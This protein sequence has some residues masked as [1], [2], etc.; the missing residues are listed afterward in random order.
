MKDIEEFK[1][2][3]PGLYETIFDEGAKAGYDDGFVKGEASGIEKGKAEGI[4]EGK[5][6]GAKME[7]ERIRN[8][9]AQL[10]PGHEKLIETLKFDG[11]TTG[12]QAAVKILQAEKELRLTVSA[13]LTQDAPP[14]VAAVAAPEVEDSGKVDK[15]LPIEKRAQAE[16]DKNP[17]LRAEFMNNFDAYLAFEKANEAG[18]V[19]ILRKS[20]Q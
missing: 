12:E 17:D 10:I 9:E 18:Q 6:E 4:A 7:R 19:R 2:K 3:Y 14:A 20:R 16:W 11:E 8:V 5:I 1:T 13:Q 15:N